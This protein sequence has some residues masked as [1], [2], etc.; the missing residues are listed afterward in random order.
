MKKSTIILVFTAFFAPVLLAVLLHSRWIDWTP[1]AATNHGE[2]I[3]PVIPISDFSAANASGEPVSKA[4]LLDRWQLV[5]LQ[6]GACDE[7][8]MERLYWMR[9]IRAAQ[10]RHRNEVGL[11]LLTTAPLPEGT[12]AEIRELAPDFVIHG[13]DRALATAADFPDR[14]AGSIYIMDPDGNIIMRYPSDADPT[15]I[16]KDLHRLLTWTKP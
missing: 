10:D 9:Q 14:A 1:E 15:G 12:V 6:P 3:D 2:L 5:L 16:R 11:M 4:D 7:T 8:C 13:G